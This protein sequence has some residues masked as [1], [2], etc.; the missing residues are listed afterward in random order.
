MGLNRHAV[1][2][3][4]HEETIATFVDENEV[5]RN[6]TVK[7]RAH[8]A[9]YMQHRADLGKVNGTAQDVADAA[10]KEFQA[11]AEVLAEQYQK[12]AD[13]L[14]KKRERKVKAAQKVQEE[15]AALLKLE[16]DKLDVLT[17][18]K[19]EAQLAAEQA[20]ATA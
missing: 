18:K 16:R 10:E 19:A 11:A 9:K 4:N 1:T 8:A 20:A 6:V 5:L 2:P 3:H 15:G 13:A 12:D 17:F 14:A 7:D